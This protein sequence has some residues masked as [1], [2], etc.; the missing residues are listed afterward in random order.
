MRKKKTY[1]DAGVLI[2]AVRGKAEVVAKAM[3][4]LD[5]PGREE[6]SGMEIKDAHVPPSEDSADK[7][8]CAAG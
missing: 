5:D 2:A 1:V 4:I 6:D 3:Q 7:N 8:H